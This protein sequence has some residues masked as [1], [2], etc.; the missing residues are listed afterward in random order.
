MF[1]TGQ[2]TEG[3]LKKHSVKK[4]KII[5]GFPGGS[6]MKNPPANAR[7]AGSVPGPGRSHLPW[8]N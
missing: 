6:V 3:V 2:A 4:K 1:P 8:S 5:K 7:D